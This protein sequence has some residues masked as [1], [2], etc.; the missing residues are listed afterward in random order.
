MTGP[1]NS[2][3]TIQLTSV[4]FARLTFLAEHVRTSVK[5]LVVGMIQ[6]STE[7]MIAGAIKETKKNELARENEGIRGR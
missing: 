3:L 7:R 5:E 2:S 1:E 6:V 4:E